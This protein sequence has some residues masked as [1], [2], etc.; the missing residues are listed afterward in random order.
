L[1]YGPVKIL[2]V[3]DEARNLDVLESLLHSPEHDLVRALTADQALMLLLEGDYAAIVLDIQMPGMSGIELANLI[4]QRKRSRHVPIIFVT[5]Y[6]QGDEDVLMGY[7]SGAVDYLTKPINP[8]ILRSK[9]AVFVDLFRKTRALGVSNAMLEMEIAQRVKA[10]EALRQ[11]NNELEARVEAR[12]ADLSRAN[13]EL[14]AREA[15]LKASEAKFKA[16]SHAKDEFLAALSHE[17]RTPLNPVLLLASH[18]VRDPVLPQAVRANFDT[19]RKNVELEARLIDDL[20]DLTRITQGVLRLDLRTIDA[21]A[22]VRDALAIV[23]PEAEEKGLAVSLELGAPEHTIRGDVVRLQQ[24]FWNLLKNAV[25]FTPAGGKISIETQ[26]SA[27][28]GEWTL[29]IADTG[30]GLTDAELDRVFEAFTQGEHAHQPG[31]H[32][33]GGLGLGLAISRTLVKMHAG[34]IEAWSDGRNKGSVFVVNLPLLREP[35]VSAPSEPAPAAAGFQT[36]SETVTQPAQTP[37]APSS[38]IGRRIRI[39]LVEDHEATRSTLAHLLG[40]LEYEVVAAGSAAEARAAKGHFDL[41]ISDIGLPDGGGCELLEELRAA[42]PGLSGIALSGYGMHEDVTR[43]RLAG[44]AEH[45][46]KPVGIDAL[47]AAILAALGA[48][49]SRKDSVD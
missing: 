44:F 14:C 3:D 22:I 35:A 43:S 37:E 8:Q 18:A 29:S 17:L 32:R 6:Y 15:A 27:E 45:L 19:I 38:S 7:G 49:A 39:L 41:V 30:I 12:T 16:A 13:D 11:A 31:S 40:C 9:I 42:R 46:T 21:H 48:C 47:D 5:A 28:S 1:K 2:L 33:F 36:R 4:K 20:L 26:M 10:E 24:V 34:R 25:K 23:R